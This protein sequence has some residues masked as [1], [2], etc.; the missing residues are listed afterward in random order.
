MTS[1]ERSLCD[2]II[3]EA[4]IKAGAIGFG[5][6]QSFAADAVILKK[7]QKNMAKKLA[8][9][10]GCSFTETYLTSLVSTYFS[11]LIGKKI[12]NSI[13]NIIPGLGNAV[14]ASTAVG[15]TRKLGWMLAEQFDHE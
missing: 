4:C 14:N 6:A 11:S 10:F 15:I 7:I 8:N 2:D 3:S 12:E 1:Y 13:L 9:V 5:L